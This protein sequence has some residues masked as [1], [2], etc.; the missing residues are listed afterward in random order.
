MISAVILTKNEEKNIIDCLESIAFCDEIIIVDD[1]SSDR[2][3]DIV[4]KFFKGNNKLRLFKRKLEGDFS[5]QRN[6]ALSKTK[7]D[8]VL[9]LDADE[10]VTPLL[11]KEIIYKLDELKDKVNGFYIRRENTL[12]G[13]TLR[14]GE[15]LFEK[16]I[17][18]AN[19]KFGKW[20]GKIHEQWEIS[21]NKEALKNSIIHHPHESINEYL[22]KINYYTDIR[23]KELYDQGERSSILKVVFYTKGKFFYNYFLKFGFLDGIRG[24]I[25]S[26]LMSFN[27]FLVRGKLWR[28]QE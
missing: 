13:K 16:H 20:S 14:Y 17:R 8:W 4:E 27:S 28:M 15:F 12:W 9:F 11:K 21:G 6:F 5:R 10:R 3:L 25:V 22:K 26:L 7:N 18:L 19:K 2:T 1:Q 23:A 24:L